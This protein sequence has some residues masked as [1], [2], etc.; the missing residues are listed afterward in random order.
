MR[1]LEHALN[2]GGAAHEHE[3]AVVVLQSLAGVE[4][5]PQAVGVEE[6]ERAQVEQDAVDAGLVGQA[7]ELGLE[8]CRREQ[9]ELAAQRDDR[10]RALELGLE[11]EPRQPRKRK[12]GV[13]RG[14]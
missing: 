11:R 2:A 8:R 10:Q 3:P 1:E 7:L 5:R 9:I 12:P 14:A 13:S 4:N 6:V